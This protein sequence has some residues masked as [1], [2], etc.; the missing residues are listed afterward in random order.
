VAGLLIVVAAM[1]VTVYFLIP[2]GRRT[3][4]SNQRNKAARR[5]SVARGKDRGRDGK[6]V[7]PQDSK[8]NGSK[9]SGTKEPEADSSDLTP[10]LD[11][12][13]AALANTFLAK[14]NAERARAKIAPVKL[15]RLSRDCLA[16][17]R[18]LLRHGRRREA[19]EAGRHD[20][21][22]TLPGASP[23][24]RAAAGLSA[25]VEREPLAAAT[26]WLAAP[27]HRAMLLHSG[28]RSAGVGVAHQEPDR[29]AVVFTIGRDQRLD[30]GAA[31]AVLYPAPGQTGVPLAFPGN[32][33]PDPIPQAKEKLAGYPVTV[34]L[35]HSARVA[36]GEAWLEDEAGGNVAVWFSTPEKPANDGH[37]RLQQ[38]TICLIAHRP[39]RP[40]TRYLVHVKARVNG[41]AWSRTWGFTTL[42]EGG[43]DRRMS[44]GVLARINAHR[45]A[46]GLRP[47][48]RDDGLTRGCAAHARYLAL[49]VKPGVAMNWREERRD[50]PGYNEEGRAVAQHCCPYVGGGSEP[51]DVVQ[52]LTASILNR[53]LVLNPMLKIGVG[54]ARHAPIGWV[55]TVYLGGTFRQGAGPAE[56]LFPAPGAKGVPLRY[57]AESPNL[58]PGGGKQA[59]YAI[60]AMMPLGTRMDRVTARLRDGEGRDVACWLSTPAQPFLAGMHAG[61][62]VLLPK[63]PLRP[64]VTYTVDMTA[65]VNGEAWQRRWGFTTQDPE[66]AMGDVAEKVLRQVNAHRKAAGLRLVKLDERLTQGCRQHARYVARNADHAAVQGLGIHKEDAS[67][68]GATPEGARAGR[69]AVIATLPDPLQAI[70]SWMSTLYHRIPILDPDLR[71]LGYGQAQLPNG[72]WVAVLD[73]GSGRGV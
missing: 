6:R 57:P 55:W 36:G 21:V 29:W 68:P 10:P 48:R 38:K 42:P 30:E 1:A 62:I 64:G 45:E 7:S 61:L 15:D 69:E 14:I 25:V 70:D 54:T 35:P 52:W 34:T 33:L 31:A 4:S 9:E 59:G 13:S 11:P 5:S 22:A 63:T 12:S 46:A 16:H 39:L 66:K 27:A 41:E 18:Y 51:G 40:D 56:I 28:V 73:V 72:H 37:A 26:A 23:A 71:R 50:L 17:A 8:Q 67:L 53:T 43:Q 19:T 60:S 2:S 44:D 20:Q 32:E 47:V 24:G 58:I 65:Q 49:N 3:V